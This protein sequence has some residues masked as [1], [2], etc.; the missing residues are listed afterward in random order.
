M[1]RRP[2]ETFPR[3]LSIRP[4]PISGT[5]RAVASA[6]C[7]FRSQR[8]GHKKH[9]T[10]SGLTLIGAEGFVAGIRGSNLDV[11]KAVVYIALPDPALIHRPI[12][13]R[14]LRWPPAMCSD[15]L[16]VVKP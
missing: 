7:R 4:R 2:A 1:G 10:Q 14:S 13:R 11:A 6:V 5:V 12:K 8:R 15:S 16:G 9:G 3:G